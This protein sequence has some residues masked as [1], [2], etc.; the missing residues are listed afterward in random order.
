MSL[1]KPL[2]VG[3][4]AIKMVARFVKFELA[5]F[6]SSCRFCQKSCKLERVQR[7][8]TATCLENLLENRK[9]IAACDNDAGWQ[10]H[11]VVEAF[12][13]GGGFTLKNEVVAHWLD[14]EHADIVLEKDR[15]D[16][17]SAYR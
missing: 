12:H 5:G 3:V 15:Q 11:C 9:R 4:G 10:I 16:F 8:K 6:R 13:G 14:T 1:A 7:V 17:G 2:R